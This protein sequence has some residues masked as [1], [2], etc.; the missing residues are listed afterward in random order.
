MF[1]EKLLNIPEESKYHPQTFA[2]D[3]KEKRK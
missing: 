2:S 1:K 3:M